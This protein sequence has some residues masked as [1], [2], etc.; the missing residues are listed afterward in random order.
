MNEDHILA[1]ILAAGLI[2]QNKSVDLKPKDAVDIYGQCLAE[3]LE[4]NRG[5]RDLAGGSQPRSGG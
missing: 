5:R 3:L 4:V 1:A 2:A